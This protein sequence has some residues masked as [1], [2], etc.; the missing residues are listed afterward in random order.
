[1]GESGHKPGDPERV[2]C[3]DIGNT[4]GSLMG[5]NVLEDILKVVEHGSSKNKYGRE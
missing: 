3:I 4:K 5:V 1:M 2:E